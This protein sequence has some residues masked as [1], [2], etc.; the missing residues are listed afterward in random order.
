[1]SSA[2]LRTDVPAL[3]SPLRRALVLIGLSLLMADGFAAENTESVSIE[4]EVPAERLRT[5]QSAVGF[6]SA[7]IRADEKSD[8]STKGLPLLYI[9]SG[10]VLLPELIKGLVEVYKDWAYG[11]TIVDATQG[12][13]SISHDPKGS[14]DVVIV[15]GNDGQISVYNNRKSFDA[16]KWSELIASATRKSPK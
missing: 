6:S 5:A 9:L 13:L 12:K 15:K 1:M 3:P 7:Q 14:A 2:H 10:V 8:K 16:S 11:S 4:W